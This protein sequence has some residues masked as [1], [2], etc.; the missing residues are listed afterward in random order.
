MKTINI[1]FP[2]TDDKEKNRFFEL[3]EV[4]KDSLTSDLVLLLLTEKGQRYYNPNYGTNLLQYIFEPKD[5]LT[6]EEIE[7][8]IKITV[9]EY[10]PELTITNVS[11]Y[12]DGEDDQG[13]VVSDNEIRVVINFIYSENTFSDNGRLV[14]NF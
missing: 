3:N 4:T 1:K 5:S 10:I 14:L 12:S 6:I 13:D 7:R 2:I 9:K 8:E 11:F